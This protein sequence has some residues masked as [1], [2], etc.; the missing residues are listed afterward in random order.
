MRREISFCAKRLVCQHTVFVM[1]VLLVILKS[2]TVGVNL[3][4]PRRDEIR[5]GLEKVDRGTP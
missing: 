2:I 4:L 3:K 1:R 5:A